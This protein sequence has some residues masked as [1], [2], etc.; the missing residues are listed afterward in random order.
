[1]TFKGEKM[2]PKLEH[3]CM[4]TYLKLIKF[5]VFELSLNVLE[6]TKTVILILPM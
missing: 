2:G 4:E 1:M 3:V 6:E 5:R